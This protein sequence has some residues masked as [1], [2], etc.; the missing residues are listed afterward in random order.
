[1]LREKGREKIIRK[2]VDAVLAN[3]LS[4]MESRTVDGAILIT[5]NGEYA[6]GPTLEK[7]EFARWLVRAIEIRLQHGIWSS[8]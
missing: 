3:S 1:M 5:K 4:T 6:P 2:G 7:D 8:P